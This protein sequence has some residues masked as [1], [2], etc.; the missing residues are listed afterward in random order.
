MCTKLFYTLLFADDATLSL[1]G[2]CPQLLIK[3]ANNELHKF[4]VWCVA[5]R[6]T[7]N[8]L[9]TFYM[10]FSNRRSNNLSPLVIKSLYNYD[11]IKKVDSTKFLG[12]HYD[13]NMS[14][15]SHINNLTQRLSRISALFYRV[16]NLMPTF[17]LKTMYHAHVTS[18]LSYCNIIWS[19]TYF[20]HLDP[21]IKSQKRLIRL[22][23][24]S[25]FLA[26]TEP[27]FKQLQLL[28]IENLRRYCLAIYFYKNQRLLLPALQGHHH[29]ETR[30]RER[31]RPI[32]HTNVISSH[33]F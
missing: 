26:H 9:K 4:Y 24:N 32:R 12:I 27:L 14:F 3:L 5:N 29:Y 31:P 20:T 6:L 25:E 13:S 8:T 16:K 15:K 1:C 11:P 21:L 10:I 28:N 7:V 17:V 19:N 2:H 23:T 22:L 33:Y 18:I 30:N